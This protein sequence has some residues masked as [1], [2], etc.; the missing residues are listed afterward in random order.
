MGSK[1][2][3]FII[4]IDT[5][6]LLLLENESNYGYDMDTMRSKNVTMANSIEF[7]I[8]FSLRYPGN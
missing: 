8:R 1:G 5:S 7:F 6:L 2:W 3:L 4:E